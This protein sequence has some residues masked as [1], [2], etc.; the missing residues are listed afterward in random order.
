[1][2]VWRAT[3]TYKNT[4]DGGFAQNV[5]HFLEPTDTMLPEQIGPLIDTQWWGSAAN[6]ALDV[7]SANNTLLDAMTVQRIDT[8]PAGGTVPI[9]VLK[10]LGQVTSNNYHHTMGLIFQLRDGV[11]GR[12]HRG[13][14]YHYGSPSTG[15]GLTRLGPSASTI[16]LFT[17]LR[18]RWML[19]FGENGT[20]GLRWVIW[21]RNQ[22][23]DDRW[24]RV[25]DVILSST[26]GC[27]RRRNPH[28]GL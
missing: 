12:A 27:Q 25:V 14:V 2:A 17:T 9:T 20:T 21:H 1:M 5:L 6:P 4:T 24:T 15:I 7:I 10:R 26:L 18:N 8:E 19:R 28:V 23:G 3:L 16:P 13:R 11:A 22:T